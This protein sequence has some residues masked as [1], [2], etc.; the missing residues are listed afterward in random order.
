MKHFLSLLSIFLIC[1]N[2][3]AQHILTILV[4]DIPASHKVEDIFVAGNFNGWDPGKTKLSFSSETKTWRIEIP[5]L[6]N[7]VYEFKFTRESW[8]KVQASLS[9]GD[10]ENNVVKLSSDTTVT[11]SIAAWKDDFGTAPAKKHTASKNVFVIDTAFKVPQLNTT[12]RIWIYLPEG[13]KNSA[14]RYPVLYMHD[15]QNLFDEFTAGFGEWGIDECLDSLIAKGKPATIVVGIDNGP[16]RMNEYNPYDVE[17]FGKGEGDEY[18]AFITQTL[19]PFIDKTYRTIPS[20]E[21]TAIAGSSMGGL[22]SYYAML[23]YPET[24]GKAGIFSPSFW[25]VPL[26]GQLAD[27]VSQNISGKIFFYAGEQESDSMVVQVQRIA[28]ITGEHSKAVIY[29]ATD[30]EGRHNET[31]WRKW[32]ERFYLWMMADGNNFIVD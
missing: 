15:G 32:F 18:L 29:S 4:K 11:F 5:D 30:P 8:N 14:K 22:I 23:K 25:L 27:S 26:I 3:Q 20:K 1:S 31:A 12:R 17:R 9:G 19:K 10:I 21:N 28:D 16:K 24:F 2:L 13:Y 6:K 7:D